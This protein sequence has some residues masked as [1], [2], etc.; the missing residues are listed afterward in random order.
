MRHRR[1][2]VRHTPDHDHLPRQRRHYTLGS[3]VLAAYA[4]SEGGIR[5]IACKGTVAN[6]QPIDTSSTG[7]KGFTVTA[8]D[9]ASNQTIKTVNYTVT[10]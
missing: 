4:C 7:T 8:T 2:R 1:I 10:A 3:T 5:P 9:K 6:G